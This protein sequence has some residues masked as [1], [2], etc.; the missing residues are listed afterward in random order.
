MK[1]AYIG[2]FSDHSFEGLVKIVTILKH[3]LSKKYDIQENII[4][5]DTK[6]IHI[7]SSGFLPAFKK[8]KY[9]SI[10]SIYGNFGISVFKDVKDN[11][12]YYKYLID[13]F[14]DYYSFPERLRKISFRIISL[15]TPLFIKRLLFKKFDKVIV[16]SEYMAKKLNLPNVQIIRHG[17]DLS[18][19]KPAPLL[20]SEKIRIAYFGHLSASKGLIEVINAFSKIDMNNVEKHIYVTKI[21]K[22]FKEYVQKIDPTIIIHGVVENIVKEYQSNDI[23]VL[24]YRHVGGA[25]GTPLV[26]VEAMACGRAVI[27]S[28]L[29]HIKEFCGDSVEYIKSCNVRNIVDKIQFLLTNQER[30]K[31]LGKKASERAKMFDQIQMI[32][33]Y[34]RLYLELI[35]KG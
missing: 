29:P 16:P 31:E 3:N 34:D 33:E 21:T 26:L 7:H 5:D 20:K 17:I 23:I 24:P 28:E 10:Y 1:I 6:L 13:P 4:S 19:F 27:V 11:Y 25:I 12:D 32:S 35:S 18:K 14:D 30:I 22:K 2:D 9:P 15:S 8:Y